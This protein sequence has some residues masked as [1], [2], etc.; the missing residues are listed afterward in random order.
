MNF[1]FALIKAFCVTMVFC[2]LIGVITIIG[3]AF[4]LAVWA[5]AFIGVGISVVTF[6][7]ALIIRMMS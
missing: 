2:C 7:F 4:G 3:A 1:M 5:A 6:I